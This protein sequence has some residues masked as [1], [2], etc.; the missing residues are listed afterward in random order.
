MFDKRVTRKDR[1]GDA[2]L[3]ERSGGSAGNHAC[4]SADALARRVDVE[5]RLTVWA[6]PTGHVFSVAEAI[7]I[8]HDAI[9]FMRKGVGRQ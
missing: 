6:E 3:E 2:L 7:Q 9:V 5:A 8:N 1:G 4:A